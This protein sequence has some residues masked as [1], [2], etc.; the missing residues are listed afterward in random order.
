VADLYAPLIEEGERLLGV[1][2]R[3]AWYDLGRPRLYVDNQVRLLHRRSGNRSLVDPEARLAPGARLA[4]SVVGAAAVV[5]AGA[6]VERSVVWDGAR[7]EEGARVLGSVVTTGA[8][9]GR[10]EIARRVAV[11]PARAIRDRRDVGGRVELRGGM[12]WVPIA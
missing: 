9:V 6:R 7:V 12:A 4:R 3:G 10:G 2:V 5:G 11:L 1:R 8:R